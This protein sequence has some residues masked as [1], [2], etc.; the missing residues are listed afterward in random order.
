MEKIDGL[1]IPRPT[2]QL[3]NVSLYFTDYFPNTTRW[4]F[5]LKAT[6]ADGLP[7]GPPRSEKAK[8]TLRE[9]A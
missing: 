6:F 7:F 1:W 3:Y 8:Q 2:D 9:A 5:T 4:R